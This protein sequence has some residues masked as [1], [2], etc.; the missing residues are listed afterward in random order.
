MELLCHTK[1]S[2]K[3]IK[4]IDVWL[5]YILQIGLLR[6]D[7]KIQIYMRRRAYL[8]IVEIQYMIANEKLKTVIILSNAELKEMVLFSEI[9]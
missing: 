1:P 3:T 9:Q 7:Y 5:I 2:Q 6:G 8:I 4:Y